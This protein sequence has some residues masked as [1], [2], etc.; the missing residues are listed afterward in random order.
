MRN[1]EEI[2]ALERLKEKTDIFVG[3]VFDFVRDL[4]N[5]HLLSNL[6]DLKMAIDLKISTLKGKEDGQRTES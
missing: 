5:I 6:Y 3:D 1:E 4:N 2:A